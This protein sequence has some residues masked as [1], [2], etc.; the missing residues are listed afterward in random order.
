MEFKTLG[1]MQKYIGRMNPQM[2]HQHMTIY[3]NGGLGYIPH[4]RNRMIGGMAFQNPD[5]G[6]Y[7]HEW[8]E[9]FG[10]NDMEELINDVVETPALSNVEKMNFLLK[11]FLDFEGDL[12]ERNL[13]INDTVAEMERSHIASKLYEH[14]QEFRE[15]GYNLTEDQAIELDKITDD[16]TYKENPLFIHEREKAIEN[17]PIEK[18]STER[19]NY[20]EDDFTN[21]YLFTDLIDGDKSK[22]YNTKLLEAYSDEFKNALV[23]IT[24]NGKYNNFNELDIIPKHEMVEIRDKI[25]HDFLQYVPIDLIKGN[26]IYEVKS[27]S[28]P[29]NQKGSQ[30]IQKSKLFGFNNKN[31]DGNLISYAFGLTDD[32]RKVENILFTYKSGKSSEIK[33]D[34]EGNLYEDE[35]Y[36]F[37]LKDIPILK[38]K[39]NGYKYIWLFSNKDT[40]GYTDPLKPDIFKN[41]LKQYEHILRM[42][43][44]NPDSES[45]KYL[46]IRNK[47]FKIMPNSYMQIF[48]D[49]LKRNLDL[50]T[51]N[52]LIKKY[53]KKTFIKD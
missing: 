2:F 27:F 51:K 46:Q 25:M 23:Y 9:D 53:V 50:K 1:D 35:T 45:N 28:K 31:E 30:N 12:K 16:P 37:I 14:I 47:N 39:P 15:K 10:V 21:S 36:K 24:S 17:F 22:L 8:F 6:R 29:L 3:G 42:E 26:T 11:E 4:K 49:R 20:T 33:E 34:K 5:T 18:E 40:T 13:S 44:K 52:K 19:G 43:L 48:K 38:N 41:L 32:E 7:T